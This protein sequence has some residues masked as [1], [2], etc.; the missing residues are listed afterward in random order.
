MNQDHYITLNISP[1]RETTQ[2]ENIKEAK[3]S[4]IPDDEQNKQLKNVEKCLNLQ[5]K[6]K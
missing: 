5:A 2:S 1:D 4:N 3:S 6:G